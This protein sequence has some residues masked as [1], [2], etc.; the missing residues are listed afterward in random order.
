MVSLEVG[1]TVA[2]QIEKR[3]CYYS[4]PLTGFRRNAVR[5]VF[6]ASLAEHVRSLVMG[7]KGVSRTSDFSNPETLKQAFAQ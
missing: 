2:T 3:R 5:Y 7:P 4:T 1:L 6:I